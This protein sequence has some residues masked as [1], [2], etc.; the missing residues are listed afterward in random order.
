MPDARLASEA[1]V[2][3]MTADISQRCRQALDALTVHNPSVVQ[4]GNAA[5]LLRSAADDLASLVELVEM[6]IA[7]TREMA[8]LPA[9]GLAFGTSAIVPPE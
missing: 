1:T 5:M 4:I 7:P 3:W 8:S 9:F 2:D 6:P